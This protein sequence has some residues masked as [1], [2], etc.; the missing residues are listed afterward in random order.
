MAEYAPGAQ[1][2]L[3]IV[4]LQMDFC[5]GGALAVAE[6]DAVVS[7]VNA[8]LDIPRW[9]KVA[10][11]DWHPADHASFQEQG[12]IWPVHCVAET[13]G[14]AFHPQ[15]RAEKVEMVVSKAT[16]RDAEAYSGFDG[17]SLANDLRAKGI[18]RLFVCGLATDYCV[19]ATALDARREGFDV[20]VVEDAVRAVNVD[21]EDGE[22][23]I[24]EMRAAGCVFALSG[25]I[26]SD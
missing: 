14:A 10:T 5:P 8:L 19:K 15:I 26:R 4:D 11:R 23:A 6:G 24:E 18:G 1:D 17:T 22:N 20:V 3:I 21:P 25:D 12:G 13:P 9:M 16:T 7:P 2:G